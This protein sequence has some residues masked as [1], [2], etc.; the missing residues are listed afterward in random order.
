[1]L[2]VAVTGPYAANGAQIGAD[3]HT[4][5]ATVTLT[6]SGQRSPR[7]T[8]R[9]L[10]DLA[11]VACTDTPKVVFEQFASAGLTAVADDV[12]VGRLSGTAEI[13]TA[14][15]DIRMVEP[16]HNLLRAGAGMTRDL[17]PSRLARGLWGLRTAR[18]SG[19]WRLGRDGWWR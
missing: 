11:T 8:Y 7:R 19:R 18:P 6:E 10:V 9:N 2:R 12:S 16:R 14:K 1:M 17:A 4:A 3:K 13:S 15:R 5:D